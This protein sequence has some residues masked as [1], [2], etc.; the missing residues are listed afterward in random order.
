MNKQKKKNRSVMIMMNKH[1]NWIPKIFY[2]NNN[3]SYTKSKAKKKKKPTTEKKK[4]NLIVKISSKC[5]KTP[6]TL[7]LEPQD[8]KNI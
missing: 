3:L 5:D 1:K 6:H 2:T 4:K 7:F 8:M